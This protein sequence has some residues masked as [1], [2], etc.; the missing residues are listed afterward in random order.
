MTNTE[1]EITSGPARVTVSATDETPVITAQPRN[2]TAV[3][4]G[5]VTFTVAA[6]GVPAPTYQWMHNGVAIDG[7]AS[8]SY[9]IAG[10]TTGNAGAY[11]VTVT[12][13]AGSVTSRN[14]IL[15]VIV[16]SFEGTYF[17]TFGSDGSQFAV[18][19]RA[20]NTGAFV[21]FDQTTSLYVVGDVTIDDTGAFTLT[22]T[23]QTP[24]ITISGTISESGSV[25]GTVEGVDGLSMTGEKQEGTETEDIAG[26]YE[27]SSNETYE[28]IY[29]VIA[30]NGRVLVLTETA[31]GADA[32]V[33]TVTSGGQ[34]SVTTVAQKTVTATVVADTATIQT[35]VTDS[36]GTMTSF[37]GGNDEVIASQRLVNIS[38]RASAGAGEAQTIAGLVITGEDSKPVL[39]RAVGPGLTDFN[40]TGVLAAPQLDLY[41]GQTVIATN[42]GWSGSADSADIIE[43]GAVAGAFPLDSANADSAILETLPPGSYTAQVSGADGGTGVVLVEVYDLSSPTLGQ[44]LFNISTRADV[45]SGNET[46]VAGFVVSGTVPKRILLLRGV[47][48]TLS[49]HDV[50]G[51]IADPIITL[52]R[53]ETVIRSNDNWT[54][55][56]ARVTAASAAAGA[57][58]LNEGSNDAAMVISLKPGVYTVHMNG[59]GGAAGVGL[60]EVYEIP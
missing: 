11:S 53:G 14:A 59:V 40:V 7:A 48:P 12:N 2:R 28:V 30:P 27:A 33:G 20:D 1:G 13:T 42:T 50:A 21:G 17:G 31:S 10:V 56:A 3:V 45:G 9:S 52:F 41:S 32:G 38:S 51:A 4:D 16:S 35:E 34:V 26:Y 44:K 55:N 15:A 49:D 19:V 24:E 60:I 6:T 43:A 29:T 25:T 37:E 39:I 5:S 22:A 23:S 36:S 46:V 54:E 58:A 57:F 8:A 18:T 47:G